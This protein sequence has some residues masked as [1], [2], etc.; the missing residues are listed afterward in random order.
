MVKKTLFFLIFILSGALTAVSAAGIYKTEDLSALAITEKDIPKGFVICR[1][2]SQLKNTLKDNPWMMDDSAVKKLTK[3]IYP[4]G[5]SA[6]VR[7]IH[8]TILAEE[9]KPWNDNIVCYM[10]LFK[11]GQYAKDENAKLKKYAD[12]NSDRA[13]LL[14]KDNLS[15]FLHADD[16]QDF[17]YIEDLASVLKNRM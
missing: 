15:I 17:H 8:M 7:N 10:I 12:F 1:I 11:N 14:T 4:E 5:N 6:A 2:P 3:H 13:I 16:T 9:K